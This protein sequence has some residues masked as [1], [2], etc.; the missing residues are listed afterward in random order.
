MSTILRILSNSSAV[1]SLLLL[2]ACTEQDS[3]PPPEQKQ[4][5]LETTGSIRAAA[6]DEKYDAFREM[7]APF[8]EMQA[9]IR[10][11]DAAIAARTA[12]PEDIARWQELTESITAERQRLNA[13]VWSNEVTG[14]DRTVMRWIMQGQP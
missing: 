14:R 9:E 7:C 8:L 10:S 4:A 2:P 5:Y 1:L 13:Y 6:E 12:S 11:L 3:G